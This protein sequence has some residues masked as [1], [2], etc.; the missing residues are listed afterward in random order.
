MH[1]FPWHSATIIG[2]N[3]L[4]LNVNG[5]NMGGDHFT[6]SAERRQPSRALIRCYRLAFAGSLRQS[7]QLLHIRAGDESAGGVLKEK[8]KR[9][10]GRKNRNDWVLTHTSLS[11]PSYLPLCPWAHH[12]SSLMDKPIK[13]KTSISL[14][15]FLSLELPILPVSLEDIR[16]YH[17]L[18]RAAASD[19]LISLALRMLSDREP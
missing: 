5:I 10:R 2:H 9:E 18:R 4:Q 8:S 1:R 15:S 19:L 3:E 16:V 12:I 6:S 17:L 13:R 14:S 11:G 7:I